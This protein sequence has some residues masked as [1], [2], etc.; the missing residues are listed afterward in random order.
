MALDPYKDYK[1]DEDGGPY[2]DS[3][4]VFILSKLRLEYKFSHKF[5]ATYGILRRL[6]VCKL[7]DEPYPEG[8]EDTV[9]P[10]LEGEPLSRFLHLEILSK[11]RDI[12]EARL[13]TIMDMIVLQAMAPEDF[14]EDRLIH[15]LEMPD[16]PD[17]KSMENWPTREIR[18][19]NMRTP[20]YR[21]ITVKTKGYF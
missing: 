9:L 16:Y 6:M 8:Y 17:R 11:L 18:V 14:P 21:W 10:D 1:T 15:K 5:D 19:A 4:Y 13:N 20:I 3:P 12:G 7:N 2:K